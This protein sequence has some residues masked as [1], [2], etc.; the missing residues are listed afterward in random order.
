[1]LKIAYLRGVGVQHRAK[2]VYIVFDTP[3][4]FT[5]QPIIMKYYIYI[6]VYLYGK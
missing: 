5:L 2:F 1:M 6:Y 3:Y 4:K